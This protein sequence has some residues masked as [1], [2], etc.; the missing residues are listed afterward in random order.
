LDLGGTGV[1]SGDLRIAESE[2]QRILSRNVTFQTNGSGLI[3]VYTVLASDWSSQVVYVTLSA[4]QA[5]GAVT[6]VSPFAVAASAVPPMFVLEVTVHRAEALVASVESDPYVRLTLGAGSVETGVR[7][8]M[9]DPNFDNQRLTLRCRGWGVRAA[10]LRVAAL[11]WLPRGAEPVALG[12]AVLD[13][14][15]MLLS[16][17]LALL[18]FLLTIGTLL[19]ITFGIGYEAW[20]STL[21]HSPNAFV[22]YLGISLGP[23]FF[24]SMLHLRIIDM[25]T[26]DP[27]SMF[28]K[29]SQLLQPHLHHPQPFPPPS[30]HPSTRR[31]SCCTPLS[32]SASKPA[33]SSAFVFSVNSPSPPILD[34]FLRKNA[35][36][37]SRSLTPS[38]SPVPSSTRCA[39]SRTRT[40]APTATTRCGLTA[41]CMRWLRA[42]RW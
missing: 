16:V 33:S 17:G 3:R 27:T 4:F 23:A 10:S 6:F 39:S 38:T 34:F 2:L 7:R 41:R 40:S 20:D 32:S 24:Y 18:Y 13:L 25:I 5:Y 11:G 15:A 9:V 21:I 36:G 1:G 42:R 19:A 28:V 14:R 29:V 12:H 8:R 26:I 22:R 35:S 37:R 31:V 30:P